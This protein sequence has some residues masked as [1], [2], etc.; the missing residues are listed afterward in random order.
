MEVRLKDVVLT[1]TFLTAILGFMP[2]AGAQGSPSDAQE[3]PSAAHHGG[4]HGSPG[5]RVEN[6]VSALKA[7]I[8]LTDEQASKVHAILTE[9][10]QAAQAD[11]GAGGTPDR[12]KFRERM[13]QN[14]EQIQA[15]LTEEQ[16]AKYAQFKEE[17]R[18]RLQ[19]GGQ[20]RPGGPEGEPAPE[21]EGEP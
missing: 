15:L 19:G 16:R 13:R 6:Q 4:R 12:A 21:P 9:S 5:A 2:F 8:G 3:N 14:D 10:A 20:H 18:Q 7:R 11:R 1:G 17:R